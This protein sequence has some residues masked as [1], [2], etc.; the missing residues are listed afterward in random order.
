MKT[1]TLLVTVEVDANAEAEA[2]ELVK[3]ALSQAK[4]AEVV[5]VEAEVADVVSDDEN[6]AED[7]RADRVMDDWDEAYE[8]AAARYDGS[9]KDWR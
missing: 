6:D 3:H 1:Y 2:I 7:D 9:G 5:F 4:K 8:R